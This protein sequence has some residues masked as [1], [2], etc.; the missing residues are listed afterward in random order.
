MPKFVVC[1]DDKCSYY[2][3]ARCKCKKITVST[4]NHPEYP[5]EEIDEDD[6]EE[7]YID[8]DEEPE[9]DPEEEY[10]EFEDEDEDDEFE[11]EDFDEDDYDV[12]SGIIPF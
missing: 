10:D 7:E 12:L 2:R 5:K 6:M 11:D 4:C 8:E 9:F 1:T 3:K